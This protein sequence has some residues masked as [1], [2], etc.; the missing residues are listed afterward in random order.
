MVARIVIRRKKR[1]KMKKWKIKRFLNNVW[2]YLSF[3]FQLP[4]F[5]TM[6]ILLAISIIC[7]LISLNTVNETLFAILSNVFAGLITGIVICL[8]SGLRSVTS[9]RIKGKIEWLEKLHNECLDFIK[10][11]KRLLF[12]DFSNDVKAY[13]KIY[14]VICVA[15][16]ITS[17]ITQSQFNKKLCFDAIKFSKKELNYDWEKNHKIYAE[18]KEKILILD[19]STTTRENIKKIFSEVLAIISKL[20]GAIV[21][22]LDELKTQQNMMERFFV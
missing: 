17:T 15:T 13:E 1:K 14:D 11:H 8:I 9:Y 16:N 7:L 5:I 22:K 12:L 18:V 3:A 21:H 19:V 2:K 4:H 10:M 6:L 20:N